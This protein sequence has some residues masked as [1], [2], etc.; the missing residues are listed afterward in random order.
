M[1]KFARGADA[2]KEASKQVQFD[3]AQYFSLKDKDEIVVR[4]LT[5][6]DEWITVDQHN[7]VPTKPEPEGHEGKWP[8]VMGTVC[9]KTKLG[10]GSTLHDDCYICDHMKRPDGKP[11]RATGRTWALAV[12][13]H[14]VKD[15]DGKVLGYR[16]GV[17][18][19]QE[20][21]KD[22]KPTGEVKKQK[23]IVVVNMGY[24][25]FFGIL[26]GFAGRYGTVLDRDYYIKRDGDD[27]NTTYHIVPLDPIE[28]KDPDDP[29][30]LIRLDL[31]DERLMK[32]YE[33][34]APD[35]EDIVERRADLE[36]YERFFIPGKGGDSSKQGGSS[37]GGS[38]SSANDS[39]GDVPDERVKEL[40]ERVRGYSKAGASGPVDLDG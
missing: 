15:E 4:F 26:Q 27:Q 3:R 10:D 22:G 14:E 2:A 31:R 40:A 12:V 1:S 7:F 32:R 37:N 24:R 21:D 5:D 38:S 25:N 30:T 16:D 6:S 9:R 23:E 18:E 29:D 19:V 8:K 20:T 28:T 35:L 39:G 33:G 11:Y 13:R 36:F 34:D 17:R